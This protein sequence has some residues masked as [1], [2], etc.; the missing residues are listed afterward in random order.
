MAKYE[1]K[2][3]QTQKVVD[4][5][6]SQYGAEPEFLWGEKYPGAAVFRNGAS[7]KWFGLIMVI[8]GTR[9][10]LETEGLV[11]V[12]D[13]RFDKGQALDFVEAANDPGICPAYHMNKR[14]WLTIVLGKSQLT[15]DAV[16]EM[17]DKSFGRSA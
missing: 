11:E 13:L 1:Y 16:L 7:K 4:Y 8:P 14:N 12:L 6:A 5:M 2:E 3:K 15:D 10:G 17:I 9:V